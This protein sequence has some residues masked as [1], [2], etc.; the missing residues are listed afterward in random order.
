[1][2]LEKE[3]AYYAE[4]LE[5]ILA[6]HEG[7]FVLIRGE[8]LAGGFTTD[9][10]AYEAGLKRYGNE[11]FLIRRAQRQEDELAHYPAL[12]LGILHAHP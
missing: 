7:Q 3:L 12:V 9:R 10:E 5:E 4:H 6:T 11:P 8:Q 2:P 1:M